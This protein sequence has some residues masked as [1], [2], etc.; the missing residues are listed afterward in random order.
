MTV[1]I[2]SGATCTVYPATCKTTEIQ[3]AVKRAEYH[4]QFENEARIL[5]ECDH[6]NIIRFIEMERTQQHLWL[7]FE[8]MSCDLGE[9]VNSKG[10]L[11][12]HEARGFAKQICGALDVSVLFSYKT[13]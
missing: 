10:R 3:Y 4:E 6:E 8:R 13:A 12:V 1:R 7:V 2:H 11:P 9:Y 5:S